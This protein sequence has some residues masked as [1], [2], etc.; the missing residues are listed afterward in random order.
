MA[1]TQAVVPQFRASKSGGVVN[2]TSSVTAMAVLRFRHTHGQH[3]H[4]IIDD[5]SAFDQLESRFGNALLGV[6]VIACAVGPGD[7][8]QP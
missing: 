3:L 8:G 2:V 5:V 7:P 1:M 4:E 6:A